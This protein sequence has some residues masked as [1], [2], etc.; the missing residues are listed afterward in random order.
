MALDQMSFQWAKPIWSIQASH[1]PKGALDPPLPRSQGTPRLTGRG[2]SAT[3]YL[4]RHGWPKEVMMLTK[5]VGLQGTSSDFMC[6]NLSL[7]SSRSILMH[8]VGA[9]MQPSIDLQR[10]PSSFLRS[11]PTPSRKIVHGS[12]VPTWRTWRSIIILTSWLSPPVGLSHSS[13]GDKS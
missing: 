2:G 12:V 7:H 4:K 5:S 10:P 8:F 11:H 1:L 3:A 6:W 9:Q 13:S